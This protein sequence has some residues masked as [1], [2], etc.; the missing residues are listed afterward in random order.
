[1]KATRL[2]GITLLTVLMC[3]CFSACGGSDDDN[4]NGG[5]GSSSAS[6]EGTWHSKSEKWYSWDKENN[7]PD[8][9][10]FYTTSGDTWI[11][12]K[13]GDNYIWRYLY[14]EHG[15]DYDET[16]ELIRVNEKEYTVRS[17][18]KDRSRI[19]FKSITKNSLELEY[20]DGYYSSSGTS[21][22]GIV[23]LVK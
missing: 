23:N 8:Y 10:D 6:I 11:F 16:R 15:R 17:N 3:V 19:L 22:F 2:F 4:D 20:Y 1:M 12:K 7:Q 5:G 13:D 18:N 14:T 21:E 9:S